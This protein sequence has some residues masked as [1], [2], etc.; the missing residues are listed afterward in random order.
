MK[1]THT[2]EALDDFGQV[3]P[4]MTS[5]AVQVSGLSMRGIRRSKMEYT[6]TPSGSLWFSST[7]PK[8]SM[9]PRML[10]NFNFP[11]QSVPQNLFS[12]SMVRASQNMFFLTL[13]KRNYK[14]V[15]AIRKGISTLVLPSALDSASK[16]LEL[17]H[18]VPSKVASHMV[19]SRQIGI[20]MLSLMVARSHI[21]L[22]A[23]IFRS[24]PRHLSDRSEL[25]TLIDGLNRC[26]LTHGNDIS[27]V[28]HVLI[29]QH[30]IIFRVQN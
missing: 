30:L 24:L 5:L 29:G 3:M 28:S 2:S 19:Q 18:F 13:L 11:S 27:I 12:I 22:V 15:Q 14:D 7:A 23:Q 8:S 20:D 21:L 1:H 25:A 4:V 26:L 6:F 10:E 16:N 9:L 17:R